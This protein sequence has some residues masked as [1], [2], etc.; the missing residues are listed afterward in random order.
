MIVYIGKSYRIVLQLLA[1]HIISPR[2]RNESLLDILTCDDF[3]TGINGLAYLFTASLAGIGYSSCGIY[4]GYCGK[5]S[6]APDVRNLAVF[7]FAYLAVCL[8]ITVCGCTRVI[9][10]T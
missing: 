9:F 3:F 6:V 4:G 5:L 10:F 1:L 8:A 2:N 7:D